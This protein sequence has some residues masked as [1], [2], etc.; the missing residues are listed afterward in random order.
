MRARHLQAI[1]VTE[2]ITFVLGAQVPTISASKCLL[3]SALG[4]QVYHNSRNSRG[5]PCAQ[6]CPGQISDTPHDDALCDLCPCNAV[7]PFCANTGVDFRRNSGG[8]DVGN[9]APQGSRDT[10]L[11]GTQTKAEVA[12]GGG[13]GNAEWIQL[14][15]TIVRAEGI[16]GPTSKSI[17]KTLQKS[18]KQRRHVRVSIPGMDEGGEVLASA[19][20]SSIPGCEPECRWEGAKGVGEELFL[21]ADRAR[22][23]DAVLELQ[24]VQCASG[25]D[26][27]LLGR[28]QTPVANAEIARSGESR[29]RWV[30]LSLDSIAKG[31]IE[32]MVSACTI[33]AEVLG[34][35]AHDESGANAEDIPVEQEVQAVPPT[36][37]DQK[38]EAEGADE[39]EGTVDSHHIQGDE[40]FAAKESQDAQ[41]TSLQKNRSLK[42]GLP[43]MPD[44]KNTLNASLTRATSL[45]SKQKEK[46]RK[47]E[48]S[49]ESEDVVSYEENGQPLAEVESNRKVVSEKEPSG[50]AWYGNH[51]LLG[52]RQGAQ[53][54]KESLE[55]KLAG[56]SGKIL[57]GREESVQHEGE[58]EPELLEDGQFSEENNQGSPRADRNSV[59]SSRSIVNPTKHGAHDEALV[60][61]LERETVHDQSGASAQAVIGH[62]QENIL[63]NANQHSQTS[64]DLSRKNYTAEGSERSE[65]RAS[66]RRVDGPSP[67]RTLLRE[68]GGGRDS[69]NSEKGG[70]ADDKGGR[71]GSGD[72]EVLDID[73]KG[74]TAGTEHE[75]E[76]IA[77]SSMAAVNAASLKAAAARLKTTLSSP[78]LAASLK[79][80]SWNRRREEGVADG[81][82]SSVA[83]TGNPE[84]AAVSSALP[85]PLSEERGELDSDPDSGSAESLSKATTSLLITVFR[86]SDLPEIL[87][88]GKFGRI[89]PNATQDPYV[90]VSSCGNAVATSTVQGGGCECRW[91]MK[92]EGESVEMRIPTSTLGSSTLAV[93]LWNKASEA[94]EV[95]VLLGSTELPL[96]DWLGK[97]ATWANLE[98]KKNRR[99]RVK[100]SVGTVEPDD[101]GGATASEESRQDPPHALTRIGGD[102]SDS[103]IVTETDFVDADSDTAGMLSGNLASAGPSSGNEATPKN[104]GEGS[105][106]ATITEYSDEGSYNPTSRMPFEAKASVALTQRTNEDCS[107]SS[108]ESKV[109]V[110]PPPP[111]AIGSISSE[112]PPQRALDEQSE[113]TRMQVATR[114]TAE[115][116]VTLKQ[117]SASDEGAESR[118]GM[119]LCQNL[120]AIACKVDIVPL[121]VGTAEVLGVRSV[122]QVSEPVPHSTIADNLSITVLVQKADSLAMATSKTAFGRPKPNV[123]QDPYVVLSVCKT[124]QATS[125]VIDGGSKCQWSGNS[126]EAVDL[127]VSYADL[128][129]AG[130][131]Q[132]AEDGPQLAV[133]VWNQESPSRL[134]DTFISSATVSL[135]TIVGSGAKWIKLSS[136]RKAR[137][138]VKI[139][140]KCHALQNSAPEGEEENTLKTQDGRSIYEEGMPGVDVD[141]VTRPTPLGPSEPTRKQGDKPEGIHTEEAEQTGDGN[142]LYIP[143]NTTT[144]EAFVS[145]LNQAILDENILCTTS[146]RGVAEGGE[147]GQQGFDTAALNQLMDGESSPPANEPSYSRQER[148]SLARDVII[149]GGKNEPAAD[150]ED[151]HIST[152][153]RNLHTSQGVSRAA[154][155][156]A[157]DALHRRPEGGTSTALEL[158]TIA[159]ITSNTALTDDSAKRAPDSNPRP[160]VASDS[161]YDPKSLSSELRSDPSPV[162]A[163]SGHQKHDGKVLQ[164]ANDGRTDNG[165]TRSSPKNEELDGDRYPPGAMNCISRDSVRQ[166]RSEGLNEQHHLAANAMGAM[167]RATV[168]RFAG[169]RTAKRLARAR[170]IIRR[171]KE[172]NRAFIHPGGSRR[173]TSIPFSFQTVSVRM[174]LAA[175]AIQG[176]FRG[177]M[178]RRN[179]RLGQRGVIKIQAM[180]RR[181]REQKQFQGL[182][183]RTRRAKV[184]EQR[185]QSRRLRI[186]SMQKVRRVRVPCHSLQSALVAGM[187]RALEVRIRIFSFGKTCSALFGNIDRNSTSFG[188]RLRVNCYG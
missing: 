129:V 16:P 61:C 45:R 92:K 10:Q 141:R 165:T 181:H 138:R 96:V 169:A 172:G 34:G 75:G 43:R 99:G 20:T 122:A 139:D 15:V 158:P 152:T 19:V 63:E 82:S 87:A 170:E 130:W 168:A 121:E 104:A 109:E 135:K 134:G 94:R 80:F 176:A 68:D 151:E 184:E 74:N 175:A 108:H 44:L 145:T 40:I 28:G 163:I 70:P 148:S 154:V 30:L 85:A 115:D 26:E 32:I 157:V 83:S 177:W 101:E 3:P 160:R 132:E 38:T 185:A 106:M 111:L 5:Y 62:A 49:L 178:T 35:A 86:A 119:D 133:E 155:T 127:V 167:S 71:G 6:H 4:V 98:L 95:D 140:V 66:A 118:M 22:V 136:G 137:G 84:Y 126:G 57:V 41:N 76:S 131:G 142:D 180:Y 153:H 147:T 54:L 91:G 67:L 182:R 14:V 149:S 56:G 37:L 120:T 13:R 60:A 183:A 166:Q 31:K 24:L 173:P 186:S 72:E 25:G 179:L 46:S 174:A 12:G 69:S 9:D 78:T 65:R 33:T 117:E 124:K 88:K 171:R 18:T 59:S 114:T 162:P 81:R 77:Q 17:F 128:V 112:S 2:Y 107:D 42:W 50:K 143:G 64:L 58:Q 47:D 23:R 8:E 188:A 21:R 1:R 55:A 79:G 103:K 89:K 51:M 48:P 116:P 73:E 187:S 93:E 156:G 146:T 97:K 29:P 90:V 105:G 110:S 11:Y 150:D 113:H 125:A 159:A 100:L 39:G 123:K 36:D 7:C 102:I 52:A 144:E 161:A 164:D 53:S 27:I